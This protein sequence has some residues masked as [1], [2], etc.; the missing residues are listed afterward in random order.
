MIHGS[1]K[2]VATGNL[3]QV[4]LTE[5]EHD[6]HIA[7]TLAPQPQTSVL[8]VNGSWNNWPIGAGRAN[9][10]VPGMGLN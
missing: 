1:Y 7:S 4:N 6:K 3:R 9:A 2:M 8:P 5:H 10:S